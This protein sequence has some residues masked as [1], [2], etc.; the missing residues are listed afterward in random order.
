M[1]E[2]YNETRVE[3]A[4]EEKKLYLYGEYSEF[5]IRIKKAFIYVEGK[6]TDIPARDIIEVTDLLNNR[7]TKLC[8]ARHLI[9]T[10]DLGEILANRQE[11]LSVRVVADVPRENNTYILNAEDLLKYQIDFNTD[12]F[13][14]ISVDS[15]QGG[16]V[17]FI[18]DQV[19][20]IVNNNYNGLKSFKFTFENEFGQ[21]ASEKV[22]VL[23]R[24]SDL[25]Q[26]EKFYQ[27]WY[28]EYI[29]VIS[30]WQKYTGKGI[31]I[32]VFDSGFL[33][34][35]VDI[36]N[37]VISKTILSSGYND[38]YMLDQH[39]LQ[40]ASI[41]ASERNNKFYIGIA[42]EA[43]I[44]SYQAFGLKKFSLV[45]LDFFQDYDII[46]NSWG[47]TKSF[48]HKENEIQHY[49]DGFRNAVN[50]GRN[51][52]GSII[53]FTSGN[54]GKYGKEPNYDGIKHGPYTIIVGGI[55][56]PIN[57]LFMENQIEYFASPGAN[58]LISAPASNIGLLFN[59][60]FVSEADKISSQDS[61][62]FDY[63][64]SFSCPM[65]SG[66][67]ALMLEANPKLGYR[68]VLEIL[69]LTALKESDGLLSQWA[70]Q[71]NK[72]D[73]WNGG[74]Y[75]FSHQYG[76]GKLNADAAVKLAESWP[77]QQGIKT[78]KTIS[79]RYPI[80]KSKLLTNTAYEIN[81]S[82]DIII[83]HLEQNI[84]IE[85][86]G[87][88]QDINLYLYSPKN[89]ISKLLYQFLSNPIENRKLSDEEVRKQYGQMNLP[90]KLN[91]TLGSTNFRGETS[92]G[93]WRI[94][95]EVTDQRTTVFVN[96]LSIKIYGKAENTPK[97]MI[98]T[99]EFNSTITELKI[100][101][102]STEQSLNS[103]LTEEQR[104]NLEQMKSRTN[105]IPEQKI[106]IINAA[107]LSSG[108]NLDLF[109]GQAEIAGIIVYINEQNKL[110]HIIATDYDDSF[111]ISGENNIII[112]LNAG[113]DKVKFCGSNNVVLLKKQTGILTVEKFNND[114]KSIHTT[115]GIFV[116]EQTT[117]L[118]GS[119]TKY[120]L[121][122]RS[123]S[124]IISIDELAKHNITECIIEYI[125]TTNNNVI[126]LDICH[127]SNDIYE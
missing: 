1:Q 51:G 26:D 37:N 24:T 90:R 107:A 54:G 93:I 58:I 108:I 76:F 115:Y 55:N 30:V 56:K 78:L 21:S 8:E 17:E 67:V 61:N 101:L 49:I 28:L 5:R 69:S 124:L 71:H 99:D 102:Q 16:Q 82:R 63:G 127:S 62:V 25:P 42:Y 95:I 11:P 66:V 118:S 98:Y 77:L 35:H 29:N 113:N 116:T 40:V 87:D 111:V 80:S 94:G 70:W 126:K 121:K 97:Q 48:D 45:N 6:E 112:T 2:N 117:D 59:S 23:L 60:F 88:F 53:I 73:T 114:P 4:P 27:Q 18:N 83:E 9:Y 15:A 72:A 123:D 125:D 57:L 44:A 104:N 68:D 32:A 96:T 81:I 13:K 19:T 3:C 33:P 34:H 119:D 110:K 7:T 109:N 103:E 106:E 47:N 39:A 50:L 65:A 46:N 41:I 31:E 89:T 100:A 10:K 92:Q 38:P 36:D 64:T 14:I 75:H 86:E 84:D 22:P 120:M 52:L 122:P 74:G 79:G 43:K 91:W 105:I 85:I 20:F 12:K